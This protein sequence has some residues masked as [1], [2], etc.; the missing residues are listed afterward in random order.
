M[1][2]GVK[3]NLL[4]RELFYQHMEGKKERM[5]AVS[6]EIDMHSLLTEFS[7]TYFT[8]TKGD[9]FWPMTF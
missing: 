6:W 5:F 3:D 1:A 8:S 7:V 9:I 4:R 2:V